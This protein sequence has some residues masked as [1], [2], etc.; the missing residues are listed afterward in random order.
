MSRA[1]TNKGQQ[2]LKAFKRRVKEADRIDIVT[3]WVTDCA[4]L[5]ALDELAKANCDVRAIVG[6]SNRITVPS[7]L[8]TLRD[9]GHVKVVD[10]SSGIFHPKV[11]I[12]H[13]D[14]R[15]THGWNGSA[16]FSKGGF[17]SN[18]ELV[19]ETKLP[20]SSTLTDWFDE[21]WNK[22]CC[23]PLT[24]ELLKDYQRRFKEK[25]GQEPGVPP[26]ASRGSATGKQAVAKGKDS[27]RI[28]I[29][30]HGVRPPP[31][32]PGNYGKEKAKGQVTVA[33]ESYAYS[34]STT[35]MKLVLEKL[36]EQDPSFLER[37]WDDSRFHRKGR[38]T[39]F[40]AR[41]KAEL[42][43]EGFR[44]H[45]IP[46]DNDW[47]LPTQTQTQEKWKVV[48]AAADVAGVEIVHRAKGQHGRE[49]KGK[50]WQAE[51]RAKKLVG[52]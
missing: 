45:A 48:E 38:R 44:K 28:V 16:N 37:C 18:Y 34:S 31:D 47:W 3:A 12:F 15:P 21:L 25:P 39:H 40:V 19:L 14:G 26:D 35:C 43:S 13:R 4:A 46:M 49:V 17:D 50:F 30:Q 23:K 29:V 5:E 24:D 11:Y 2:L 22:R 36:Q 10:P 9:M 8:E 52:F 42:G 41:T 32:V 1:L 6:L 27:K 33:G 51:K 7:A 20:A